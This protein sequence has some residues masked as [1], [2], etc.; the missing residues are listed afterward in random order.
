MKGNLCLNIT[1]KNT[2]HYHLKLGN[3]LYMFDFA[4]NQ[5][6]INGYEYDFELLWDEIVESFF[7]VI[8]KLFEWLQ[9]KQH[10]RCFNLP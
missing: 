6:Q 7:T 9:N 4:I 5:Q 8:I 2:A 10:G 3:L 1:R